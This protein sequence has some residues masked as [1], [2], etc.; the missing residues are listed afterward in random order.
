MRKFKRYAT[1]ILLVVL[2]GFGCDKDGS[3][4]YGEM[5]A[6]FEGKKVALDPEVRYYANDFENGLITITGRNCSEGKVVVILKAPLSV[7]NYILGRDEFDIDFLRNSAV[8]CRTSGKT[9]SREV[10]EGRLSV[11]ELTDSRIKGTF[12]FVYYLIRST[13]SGTSTIENGTFDVVRVEPF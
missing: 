4:S 2:T 3:D 7:G 10:I 1:V 6:V 11:I 9:N 8:A 5:G 13:D 12:S